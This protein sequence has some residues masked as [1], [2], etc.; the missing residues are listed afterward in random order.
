[1]KVAFIGATKGIGRALARLLAARG[2]ALFLLGRDREDLER[3]ARDLEVRGA[4]APVGT[5]A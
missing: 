1:M 4:R 5:A 3:S 2:D